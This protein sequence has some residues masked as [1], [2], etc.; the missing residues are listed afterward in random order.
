M[1]KYEETVR[2]AENLGNLVKYLH[3][4][5]VCHSSISDVNILIDSSSKIKMA[6]FSYAEELHDSTSLRKF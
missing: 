3:D 5:K 6:N 2:V 1:D 4:V